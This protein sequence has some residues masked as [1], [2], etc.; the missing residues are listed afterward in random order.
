M[1]YTYNQTKNKRQLKTVAEYQAAVA[2]AGAAAGALVA[3]V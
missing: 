2:A 1:Y 3:V